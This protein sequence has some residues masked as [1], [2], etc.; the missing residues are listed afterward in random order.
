MPKVA[1]NTLRG[2]KIPLYLFV[3]IA[4]IGLGRSLIH[5]FAPD[6]GAGSI[7][8]MDLSVS[9]ADEVV[10]AFA[11]WGSAQLIYAVLQWIVILRY[12]SLVPLMWAV[13][14][15]ETCGR[16]LA[17]SLKPVVFSHTPPGA[18]QNYIYLVLSIAMIAL[19]V[20]TARK[21]QSA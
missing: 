9:G 18:A 21:S 15:L 13:Q 4:A 2:S 17:G 6:G 7:A 19:S 14:L 10:F 1:T 16:M 11:L 5:I 20:W 12:R 8:G 3:V